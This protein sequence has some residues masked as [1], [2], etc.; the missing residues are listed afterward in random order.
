MKPEVRVTA[1]CIAALAIFYA[2]MAGTA[3]AATCGGSTSQ[4]FEDVPVNTADKG[5]EVLHIVSISKGDVIV[6]WLYE[7]RDASLWFGA[8]APAF[9]VRLVADVFRA[10]L[11]ARTLSAYAVPMSG[12]MNLGALQ[13]QDYVLHG[14]F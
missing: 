9:D 4:L 8:R 2:S 11:N 5:H 1:L 14:C 7:D 13:K 6:A 12:T 3:T 10:R